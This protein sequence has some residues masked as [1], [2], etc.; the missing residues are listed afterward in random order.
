MRFIVAMLGIITLGCE[1]HEP[2]VVAGRGLEFSL[3]RTEKLT[4]APLISADDQ[5]LESFKSGHGYG[6]GGCPCGN[7]APA[8]N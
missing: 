8:I 1:N 5:W 7:G 4:L 2:G 6:G 3:D